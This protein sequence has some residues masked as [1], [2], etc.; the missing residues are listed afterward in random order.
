MKEEKKEKKNP[1]RIQ[2]PIRLL[3]IGDEEKGYAML[4]DFSVATFPI[5]HSLGN[6]SEKKKNT[7]IIIPFW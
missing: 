5:S 4:R 7:G 3:R 1:T 6:I 2:I